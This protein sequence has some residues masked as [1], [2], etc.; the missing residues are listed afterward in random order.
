M[1]WNGGT[2]IFDCVAKEL[3][4]IFD[5]LSSPIYSEDTLKNKVLTSLLKVL[6][7]QDWD[8]QQESEYYDDPVIG[9]ILGN[10]FKE[11]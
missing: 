5:H 4:L 9:K 1:G 11:E 2:E 8:N 6:E 3:D 10:T 7:Y